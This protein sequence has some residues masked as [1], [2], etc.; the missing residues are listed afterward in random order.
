MSAQQTIERI[1]REKI[2]AVV[3][4]KDTSRIEDVLAAIIAGGITTIEIT[5]NSPDALRIIHDARKQYPKCLFGAGTV[6]GYDATVEAIESGAQFVVSPV[7][8]I[9]M[10]AVAKEIGVPSFAGALT[11][12]EAWQAHLAGADFVKLFPL[13]GLG[14]Q[15]LRAMRGPLDMIRFVPT[16]GV[17]VENAKEWLTVGSAAIGIGSPLVSDHDMTLS[18]FQIITSRAQQVIAAI[19]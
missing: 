9:D 16:N 15:Y 13:T 1:L 7:T 10:I 5:L 3:R 8:D 11:P 17:T 19:S 6:I 18:D 12:T 4:L 14:P 2:F